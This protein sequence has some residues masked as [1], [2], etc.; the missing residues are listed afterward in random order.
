MARASDDPTR[1]AP[2]IRMNTDLILDSP[3]VAGQP[4][5]RT[6]LG[7]ALVISA[8][9]M[10]SLNASLARFL[11]DDGL[12]AMRLSELR[13]VGA[14]AI[15]V[16]I[17][18]AVRP[19]DIRVRREH[20]P[21]LAFLGIAGLAAVYVTYFVAIDRLQIG[22]ALT[23]EYLAPLFI[24][25]WLTVV[26]GRRLS[27]GLW[28]AVMVSLAGCV[29]VVRA[30]DPGS[31]DVLGIAAGVGAGISYAIYL[32]G[33]GRAGRRHPPHTPPPWG[34]RFA[35]PFW[36]CIQPPWSFPFDQLDTSEDA[37]LALAGGG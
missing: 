8:V 30:Y 10:W 34:F 31:L 37:L 27:P 12:S 1:P 17:L 25:L 6:A 7:Y 22:V 29:L 16:A 13:S 9:T 15:L 14:F 32:A 4:T 18:L 33:G 21:Q 23:L 26:H 19:Q 3:A 24:L 28:G 5:G 35:P 2:T 36:I 20:V 11:L